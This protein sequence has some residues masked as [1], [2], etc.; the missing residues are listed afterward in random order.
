MTFTKPKQD[1]FHVDHKE[2]VDPLPFKIKYSKNIL[3]FYCRSCLERGDLSNF[4]FSFRGMD[5]ECEVFHAIKVLS[6]V[7]YVVGVCE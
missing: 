5:M 6:C 7:M 2:F 1:C 3:L 4:S